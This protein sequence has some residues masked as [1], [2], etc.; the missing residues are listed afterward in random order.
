M[1][2][3]FCQFNKAFVV[4]CLLLVTHFGYPI[5]QNCWQPH[6]FSNGGT[7]EILILQELNL[8]ELNKKYYP[9]LTSTKEREREELGKKRT[10]IESIKKYGFICLFGLAGEYVQSFGKQNGKYGLGSKP[11]WSGTNKMTI[12]TNDG[13]SDLD[14][15][16]F[17]LGETKSE[18]MITLSPVVQE[19]GVTL[20]NYALQNKNSPGLYIKAKVTY[21]ATYVNPITC[22][23]LAQQTSSIFGEGVYYPLPLLQYNSLTEAFHG[24][25]SYQ[26]PLYRFGKIQRCRS[27][28]LGTGDS[29]VVGGW[30]FVVQENAHAGVG[31]KF[32]YPMGNW[33]L[34]E[35]M[36]E[37]IFGS[38]GHPGLG[39]DVSAHYTFSLKNEDEIS[40]WLQSDFMH[41]FPGRKPN[42]R[43]FDLKANGPGSK[44]LLLQQW[45]Y[46]LIDGVQQWDPFPAFLQP[47]INYTTVPVLS[48]FPIE[49]DMTVMIDYRNH[50]LDFG[51]AVE[52]WARSKESLAIDHCETLQY[53]KEVGYDYNLNHYAVAGRQIA[54]YGGT[55]WCEPLAKIN[56]SKPAQGEINHYPLQVKDGRNPANRIPQVWEDAFDIEGA[57]MRR[58]VTG[59]FV[60]QVGYTILKHKNTPHFSLYGGVELSSKKSQIDNMWSCGLVMAI[61]Y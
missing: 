2:Y 1:K 57:T 32:S 37:P 38:A 11:F 61:Q 24:G 49:A 17:G 14:A 10:D 21:G 41:Y 26:M 52:F 56:Q 4:F 20:F 25:Y 12:G 55:R 42:L 19:I 30:N 15:Y 47:A 39:L 34:S 51:I 18:G 54:Q 23:V 31:M 59:K 9:E 44:Y 6:S 50:N 48:S 7:R 40:V 58:V 27:K 36:L 29:S 28:Y 16:Q 45:G 46:A 43:S 3:G 60:G 35:F 22:E 13:K 33:P 5:S 53:E 8:K